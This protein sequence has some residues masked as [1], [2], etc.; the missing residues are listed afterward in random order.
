MTP[1]PKFCTA[2]ELDPLTAQFL[3]ARFCGFLGKLREVLKHREDA[4]VPIPD[5]NALFTIAT[6][7]LAEAE[8]PQD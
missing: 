4:G 1:Y 6:T 8:I 7:I 3:N 2:Q 5:I